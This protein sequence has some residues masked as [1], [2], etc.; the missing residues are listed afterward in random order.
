MQH[1]GLVQVGE[2]GHVLYL[3]ELGR[4]HLLRGVDVHSHLLR[5][6]MMEGYVARGSE[7]E[8][9]KKIHRYIP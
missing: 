6:G 9:A 3:L 7:G 2:T 8:K 5:D 1:A 4:V